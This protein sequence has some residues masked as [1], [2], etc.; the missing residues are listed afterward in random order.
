M[1]ERQG[2]IF[3]SG[4]VSP[5]PL[6]FE[7]A[8]QIFIQWP[9]ADPLAAILRFGGWTIDDVVADP[10][11][12]RTVRILWGVLKASKRVEEARERRQD[13]RLRVRWRREGL[14][15]P[16]PVCASLKPCSCPVE[17]LLPLL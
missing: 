1:D 3:G 4:P 8:K 6:D 15:V 9:W 11:I 17:A 12:A 16:C 10:R 7:P 13:V 14:P 2:D 5:L